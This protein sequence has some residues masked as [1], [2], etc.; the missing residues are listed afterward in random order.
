MVNN[1][2]SINQLFFILILAL[3]FTSI[4]K[5]YATTDEWSSLSSG[6]HSFRD[7]GNDYFVSLKMKK[8]DPNEARVLFFNYKLAEK[9][10]L[11]IPENADK[12]E[13]LILDHFAVMVDH[14]CDPHEQD[15]N[16]SMFATR[17]MDSV[18]KDPNLDARGDGRAV[19]AG[20]W[21]TKKGGKKYYYDVVLK[22]V[23]KTT[24]EWQGH[25]E[26]SHKDGLQSQREG[27][28]SYM[29]G[30]INARNQIDASTDL[31]VIELKNHTKQNE[32][33]GDQAATIT[34]RIGQ[35]TRMGH[36]SY[37]A[38]DEEPGKYTSI[39]NYSVKRALGSDINKDLSIQDYR[40]YL[41]YFVENLADNAARLE[42]LHA[43][44]GSLT[45]GNMT[46]LGQLID[47]GTWK[48]QD[49]NHHGCIVSTPGGSVETEG[50]KSR[51]RRAIKSYIKDF[52]AYLK[53][54]DASL[55]SDLADLEDNLNQRF[56]DLYKLKRKQYA[57]VRSSS[58]VD[59]ILLNNDLKV[60]VDSLMENYA[61]FY[62]QQIELSNEQKKKMGIPE[63]CS[64]YVSA[65]NQR[66]ML[67]AI[68]GF[69]ANEKWNEWQG[70][71]GSILGACYGHAKPKC[72]DTVLDVSLN[73]WVKELSTD[74]CVFYKLIQN[75]ETLTSKV[76][77]AHEIQ[78]DQNRSRECNNMGR[79]DTNNCSLEFWNNFKNKDKHHN[80]VDCR[81][82]HIV[83]PLAAPY[84]DQHL[85]PRS[86]REKSLQKAREWLA[87]K[88]YR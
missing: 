17:Y 41:A 86:T 83:D 43:L 78:I 42:D 18:G 73:E 33:F 65:N 47:F 52:F 10:N 81:D 26:G 51:Q 72:W 9:I 14:P 50:C 12:L 5:V 70:Y 84:L 58:I 40:L 20:E 49:G 62:S 46:T 57:L 60:I 4:A 39:L 25:Q 27:V 2:F 19:W 61:I 23:G 74:S 1:I 32:K 36:L 66:R 59:K 79:P 63:D 44:H 76:K 7:L 82:E 22:G 16:G 38:K 77:A 21:I 11:K 37:W 55:Y 64:Y 56:D 45:R 75:I 69:F 6:K 35:Q 67:P 28:H 85:Y 54:G 3:N 48:Y 30:A 13:A 68:A 15:M 87:S 29:V 34:V 31:A 8:I 80:G 71:E 24:L 88:G 53:D